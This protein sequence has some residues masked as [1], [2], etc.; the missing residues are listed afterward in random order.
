METFQQN[1]G[2][3]RNK[4]LQTGLIVMAVLL[5]LSLLFMTVF[6]IRDS[7]TNKEK[8][9]LEADRLTLLDNYEQLQTEKSESDLQASSLEQQLNEL[10]TNTEEQLQAKDMQ[11][12]A[13]RR[14]GREANELQKELDAYKEMEVDFEKVKKQY[15]QLLLEY[16]DLD[17]KHNNL[18]KEHALMADSINQS[19]GLQVYHIRP[20]THWER[21]LWADRYHVDK[22]RRV[23]QTHL[24]FEIAGNLFTKEGSH[25]VYLVMLDPEGA[26]VA[27]A[28]EPF[29]ETQSGQEK[30]FT[31][32][33]VIDY[34]GVNL[35][36]QF[37]IT[38][39]DG[40]NPGTYT[41]QV[42][43]DGDMVRTSQLQLE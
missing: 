14:L 28:P 31:E 13:L 20:L 35:L 29:I 3:K 16:E 6:I 32:K 1:P 17:L 10:K 36:M 12:A 24:S 11:I 2:N 37:A 38:H 25:T 19:R 18:V 7:R 27:P 23:D 33:Q 39:P 30:F 40:L 34:Q 42:Y 22:A 4:N 26:V 15:A 9:L 43:I 41:Y 5:L 21:W 8:E